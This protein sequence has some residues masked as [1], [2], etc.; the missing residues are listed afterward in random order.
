[1]FQRLLEALVSRCPE[2]SLLHLE[3]AEAQKQ[4]GVISASKAVYIIIGLLVG[5]P[6]VIAS[7]AMIS[8]ML[9]DHR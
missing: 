5:V 2:P 9:G 8:R 6:V 3:P 4:V 1:M 7:I